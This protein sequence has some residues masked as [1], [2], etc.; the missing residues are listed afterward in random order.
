M[1]TSQVLYALDYR[2]R[3]REL[4]RTL[5]PVWSAPWSFNAIHT[6]IYTRKDALWIAQPGEGL[7]EIGPA[8]DPGTWT[9]WKVDL[10]SIGPG[11][12]SDPV[13]VTRGGSVV[14]IEADG[15]VRTLFDTRAAGETVSA[16]GL[17]DDR[18]ILKRYEESGDFFELWM[19][20]RIWRRDGAGYGIVPHGG[21]LLRLTSGTLERID[22][23]TGQT[24]WS[25]MLA[26]RAIAGVCGDQVWLCGD[27]LLLSVDLESGALRHEVRLTNNRYA[28]GILDEA[29]HYH[30]VN[31]LRYQA[32]D[33]AGDGALLADDRIEGANTAPG[34]LAR[35]AANDRI[36][37]STDYGHLFLFDRTHRDT[38]TRIATFPP[39]VPEFG[40]AQGGL[41]ILTQGELRCF[42]E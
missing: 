31:G 21:S 26:V 33:L 41:W 8:R 11:W 22:W 30:S 3:P 16:I 5:R 14:R 34:N 7:I 36:V 12:Q 10:C 37:F 6:R 32:Y 38:L 4:A 24:K 19:D 23:M 35:L 13:A 9:R 39:P 28:E 15:K 2:A 42:G 25:A 18:L 29:G 20:R 1:I 40:I 27:A 17:P